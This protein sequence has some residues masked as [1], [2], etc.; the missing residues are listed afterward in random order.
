LVAAVLAAIVAGGAHAQSNRTFVSGKGVDTNPCSLTAPCRSFAQAITLTNAGGEITILDPAGYGPVTITKAISIV[1]DGVGEAGVTQTSST[2][3]AITISAGGQDVVNLRGLTLV[4]GGV[5]TNNTNNGVQINSVGTLNMQNCVIR[6]FGNAAVN[7]VSGGITLAIQDTIASGNFYGFVL[8][9]SAGIN[10]A[11]FERDQ[12][13]G[14]TVQGFLVGNAGSAFILATA[15]DSVASGNQ[16]GMEVSFPATFTI[17]G[18]TIANNQIG[19]VSLN[20]SAVMLLSRTVVS[21]SSQHGFQIASG[22]VIDTFSNNTI[23][24][25]NNSGS[26]TP[27]GQQ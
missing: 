2:D 18:S 4:G 6:G 24:D 9:P 21:G 8:Q 13:L 16:T 10:I 27:V 19:L 1:N 15:V 26:L 20:S 17:V 5:A 14:N 23:T 3:N 25:T 11:V 7:S 22:G 12:A